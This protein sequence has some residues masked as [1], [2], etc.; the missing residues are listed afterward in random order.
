MGELKQILLV[1]DSRNDVGLILSALEEYKL[2]NRVVVK[3]DGAEAL[4]YLSDL[5]RSS[6][7]L[8]VLVLLDVKMPKV[9]GLQVLR[10]MKADEALK[11]VPVV[12]L[13]SSREQ[14][15]LIRSYDLGANSYVVKPVRFTEFVDA[16]KKLGVYWIL[17]NEAPPYQPDRPGP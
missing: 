12:M 16:V 13:T 4:E 9:D 6:A 8:P 15:D 14:T 2:A 7:D 1:E 5:A 17:L 11:K 3:R 10:T